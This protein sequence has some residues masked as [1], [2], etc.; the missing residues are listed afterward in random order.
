MS[1]QQTKGGQT[2]DIE[3]NK[4][5]VIT[6]SDNADITFVGAKVHCN[7]TGNYNLELEGD[8]EPQILFLVAGVTYPFRLKRL[9]LTNTD[10]PLGL[11]G[12]TNVGVIG[13]Q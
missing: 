13:A 5:F 2:A 1:R 6:A 8:V 12:V 7:N 3:P 10:Y 9:W 11:V 4:S